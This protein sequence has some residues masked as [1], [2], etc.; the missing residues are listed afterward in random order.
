MR[1]EIGG[2]ASIRGD[3]A[4]HVRNH[5]KPIVESG[6]G[7]SCLLVQHIHQCVG[8]LYQLWR[9]PESTVPQRLSIAICDTITSKMLPFGSVG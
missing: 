1:S 7:L 2:P 5:A 3:G 8:L 4:H 6:R 9:H